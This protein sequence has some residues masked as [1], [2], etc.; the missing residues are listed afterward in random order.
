[1]RYNV[2]D[3]ITRTPIDFTFENTF[4]GKIGEAFET[5]HSIYE[6]DMIV[7][8]PD[9]KP[10]LMSRRERACRFCFK[11]YPEVTFRNE[12]HVFPRLMGNRNIIHD[13]ECDTCNAM[14][15][16]Y[17]DSFSKF[18]GMS[19]TTDFI[20]GKAGI[21]SFE[22]GDGKFKMQY[23]TDKAG[24]H[25]IKLLGSALD[26]KGVE[27]GIELVATKQAYIPLHV[28]KSLYKIGYSMVD[29]VDILHFN[30]TRKII[31][32]NELDGIFKGFAGV[33]KFTYPSVAHSPMAVR[34]KKK[35]GC[36]N[37]RH[38]S[39]VIMIH[40]N[41]YAYEFF[42]VDN[43]DTFMFEQN[44]A[45]QFLFAPPPFPGIQNDLLTEKITLS[46]PVRKEGEI[47]SVIFAFEQEDE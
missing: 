28:L 36:D 8:H 6:P 22:S 42:L 45:F 26:I 29:P 13:C 34:Y 20:K 18:L 25:L 19:R 30:P 2:F 27:N 43:R 38:P 11:K 21:P 9:K 37:L 41:R 35:T 10:K 15:G 14:F 4:S 32:S 24:K 44:A 3:Y 17:E 46:S 7:T 39:T 31:I 1:M 33:V 40:F 47:D 5:F 16:T 23:G 12:A